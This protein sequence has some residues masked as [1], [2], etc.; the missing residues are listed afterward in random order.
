MFEFHYENN[1]YKAKFWI[2]V[3]P[4]NF[5]I[6]A[7]DKLNNNAFIHSKNIKN[8]PVKL[9]CLRSTSISLSQNEL[10]NIREIEKE[11]IDII[12]FKNV[13]LE[14]LDFI[15][16]L[17]LYRRLNFIKSGESYMLKDKIYISMKKT[18][19]DYEEKGKVDFKDD[20]TDL[21]SLSFNIEE[22][23]SDD[24]EIRKLI[25]E[26]MI[27]LKIKI[28]SK[29]NIGDLLD[30]KNKFEE[31]LNKKDDLQ[32]YGYG[33]SYF[34]LK[35]RIKPALEVLLKLKEDLMLT[36][37]FN[38]TRKALLVNPFKVSLKSLENSM[39][40]EG[41]FK[42]IEDSRFDYE[43]AFYEDLGIETEISEEIRSINRLN[44][45]MISKHLFLLAKD[46]LKDVSLK[47]EKFIDSYKYSLVIYGEIDYLI[48]FVNYVLKT[49]I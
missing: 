29:M 12:D 17:S 5:L 26:F 15:T 41:K 16:L 33:I 6:M 25:E 34:T 1:I 11:N 49:M 36:E 8:L 44:Y 46:A 31:I 48:F 19:Y 7:E 21:I 42:F 45:E 4:N 35:N 9:T 20:L 38:I 43:Y 14:K 28:Y 24:E 23:L 47:D 2:E 30:E 37:I 18:L 32:E 22:Y 3:E 40:S 39:E 10:Y 27:F 13:N